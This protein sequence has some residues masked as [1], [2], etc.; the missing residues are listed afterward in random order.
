MISQSFICHYI[1]LTI[2]LTDRP[3]IKEEPEGVFIG[4]APDTVYYVHIEE[5][6]AEKEAYLKR[7]EETAAKNAKKREQDEEN[8]K[9]GL[10]DLVIEKR[11]GCSCIEGNPCLDAYGCKDWQN[12]FEVAKKHGW[13]GF[14]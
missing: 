10:A 8:E 5:D 13:K 6:S 7:A 4:L 3:L 12:R 2:G 14:S 1:H 11:E 9:N